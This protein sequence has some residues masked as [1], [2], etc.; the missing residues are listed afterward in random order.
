VTS[1]LHHSTA[2]RSE[3]P[4]SSVIVR[5]ACPERLPGAPLSVPDQSIAFTKCRQHFDRQG[6]ESAFPV[7]PFFAE[8]RV[9]I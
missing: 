4:S 1:L 6:F 2:S 5:S 3:R 7:G 9:G 8:Y